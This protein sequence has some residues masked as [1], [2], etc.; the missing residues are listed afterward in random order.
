[1]DSRKIWK[2]NTYQLTVSRT[3]KQQKSL[4]DAIRHFRIAA[5]LD[6]QNA[7]PRYLLAFA[8]LSKGESQQADEVLQ[9]TFSRK[10]WSLYTR[11]TRQA[12]LILFEDSATAS[13]ML[14]PVEVQAVAVNDSF[15]MPSAFRYLTRALV[16]LAEKNRMEG[17]R[18]RALFY[19]QSSLNLGHVMS[20]GADNLLDGIT[21]NSIT[22]LTSG[23]FIDKAEKQHIQQLKISREQKAQ[24]MQDIRSRNFQAYLAS[25]GQSKLGQIYAGDVANA[26][27]L[28]KK[29][30]ASLNEDM[31][32]LMEAAGS[33]SMIS[34]Y[35]GLFH[36]G[37]VL[38][39]LL[40]VGFLSL[41][42]RSWR[43]KGTAPSWRLREWFVMIVLLC[44]PSYIAA[45]YGS[46]LMPFENETIRKTIGP[47]KTV[48][49]VVF[50]IA[51]LI[52]I[53]L[54]L[55]IP[56]IG[57]IRKRHRQSPEIRLNKFQAILASFRIL[58]PPTFAVLLLVAL[59]LTISAQLKIQRW[60]DEEKKI[61]QMGEINYWNSVA[62]EGK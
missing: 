16:Y 32:L 49:F 50:A 33:R 18:D 31:K 38:T 59:A 27:Q 23:N 55:L 53:L 7:A 60:A 57:S 35:V 19:Y 62:R 61:I 44:A 48:P 10:Q 56:V 21:A 54:T 47:W 24:R 9:K 12:I 39:L 14:M 36:L 8:L 22:F 58:L 3:A 34:F 15:T 11:E 40:S 46:L 29:S 37:Y 17:N 42:Y 52:G 30:T 41:A 20:V 13:T 43:C 6:P 26:Q 5:T 45:Y 1:M 51:A 25:L 28:K 4:D 2:G